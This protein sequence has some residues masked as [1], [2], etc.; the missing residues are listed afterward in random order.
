VC[1]LQRYQTKPEDAELVTSN[2]E[3]ERYRFPG[4]AGVTGTGVSIM[5]EP[6][7]LNFMTEERQCKCPAPTFCKSSKYPIGLSVIL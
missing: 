6:F 4:Y 7:P 2:V 1:K 3:Q 5:G